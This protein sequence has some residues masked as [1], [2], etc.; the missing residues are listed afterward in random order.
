MQITLPKNQA[1]YEY[2]QRALAS[3]ARRQLAAL[4]RDKNSQVIFSEH[5]RKKALRPRDS[6][7]NVSVSD[8]ETGKL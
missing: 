7:C 6:W 1:P 3:S 5:S 8:D 2:T 4:Q